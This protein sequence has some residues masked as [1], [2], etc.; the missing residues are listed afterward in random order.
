LS[1]Q[2]GIVPFVGPFISLEFL[3]NP[4]M[5][6]G[7][8]IFAKAYWLQLD[9]RQVSYSYYAGT[10]QDFKVAATSFSEHFFLLFIKSQCVQERCLI[11]WFLPLPLLVLENNLLQQCSP[12]FNSNYSTG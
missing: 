9:L 10:D 12:E 11:R 8:T 2:L 3:L 4:S 6:L 7:M 5:D 1:H